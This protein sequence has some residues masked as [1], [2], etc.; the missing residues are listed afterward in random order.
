MKQL[1]TE[2]RSPT[3]ISWSVPPLCPLSSPP[4]Q[5]PGENEAAPREWDQAVKSSRCTQLES[6][7]WKQ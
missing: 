7:E 2:R 3:G 6:E 4:G 1:I 5:E